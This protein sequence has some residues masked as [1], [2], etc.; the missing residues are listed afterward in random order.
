MSTFDLNLPE[1]LK[2]FVDQQVVTRGYGSPS[3]F[4]QSLLEAEQQ[5]QVGREVEALLLE[6]VEGPFTE[7]TD[8]DVENIRLAGRKIIEKRRG[9]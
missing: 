7:W 3:E 4:V 1:S 5:R 9:R 2:A 6:T 8:D